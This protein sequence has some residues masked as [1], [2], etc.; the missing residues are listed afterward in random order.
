MINENDSI[1]SHDDN[2]IEVKLWEYIDGLSQPSEQ[3][4][5]EKLIVE[6]TEWK[7]KYHELLELHQ[8]IQSTELEQPSMRFTK[9][10]MEEIAK[11]QIAPA[12]KEYINKKIIWGLGGFFVTL[13]LGFL[14]YGFSQ[15]NWSTGNTSS[16]IGVDL[17]KIDYSKMFNNDYV[18]YFM[19][20]NVVLGLVL[21]DRF[22]SSKKKKFLDEA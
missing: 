5:I 14:V 20:L 4:A 18:N 6:N 21:L 11:Y 17:T 13:I 8:M 2:S 1:N 22:L 12:A 3:S 15:V 7:T 9:N 10:V 19:M 16:G